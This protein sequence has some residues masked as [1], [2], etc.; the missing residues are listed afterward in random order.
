M[1]T[2][3]INTFQPYNPPAKSSSPAKT[4][5]SPITLPLNHLPP[6]QFFWYF[7]FRFQDLKIRYP[8]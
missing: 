6:F 3:F 2:C 1:N 8:G 5:F 7:E 4:C